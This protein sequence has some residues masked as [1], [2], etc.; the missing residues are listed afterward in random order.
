MCRMCVRVGVCALMIVTIFHRTTQTSNTVTL[1]SYETLLTKDCLPLLY[2]PT[3]FSL[4]L[5]YNFFSRATHEKLT[6]SA[7]SKGEKYAMK[8]KND[9]V[10][11]RHGHK[12]ATA[13]N[14]QCIN[15]LLS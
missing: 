6:R 2:S 13:S 11:R 14:M 4:F 5:R 7:C 1:C 15:K 9:V 3:E 8:A 10:F 12:E